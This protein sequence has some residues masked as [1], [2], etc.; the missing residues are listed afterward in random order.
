MAWE[1]QQ[2]SN[3]M[4]AIDI[5]RRQ[6]AEEFPDLNTL[7]MGILGR[8]IRLTKHLETHIAQWLKEHGLLMGE[9]DVL[10]TLRRSG[11]PYRMTP[12]DLL[13]SM[14]L[15]SGAM[16]NRLDKL[17]GKQFIIRQHSETDRRS[18]E[19]VLT[20]AGLEIINGVIDAYVQQQANLMDCFSQA[21]LVN[22]DSELSTWLNKF[23]S[24]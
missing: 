3:D 7:P 9:F 18:V 1:R 6:W 4:D 24:N 5:I 13:N 8:L 22:I 11:A 2:S 12:S 20:D 21:Q 16:T 23:E 17:E 10:M 19:V 15:T 14:M